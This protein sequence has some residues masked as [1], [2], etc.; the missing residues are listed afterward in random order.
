VIKQA[1]RK[2]IPGKLRLEATADGRLGLLDWAVGHGS[3]LFRGSLACGRSQRSYQPIGGVL[4]YAQ[5]FERLQ[6]L[7]VE[8]N[9][10]RLHGRIPLRGIFQG[11]DGLLLDV[12][13]F[14]HL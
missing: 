8:T 9:H 4:K 2:A 6:G 14:N 1:F 13:H 3:P 11:G 7:L 12:G 10:L 5:L